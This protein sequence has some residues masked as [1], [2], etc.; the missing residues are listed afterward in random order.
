M[1]MYTSTDTSCVK[2]IFDFHALQIL[3]NTYTFDML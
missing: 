2:F 3:L 1:F